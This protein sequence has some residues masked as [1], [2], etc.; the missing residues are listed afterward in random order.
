MIEERQ[1]CKDGEENADAEH[2]VQPSG[3]LRLTG[4]RE[5]Q[6]FFTSKAERQGELGRGRFG[7]RGDG[8]AEAGQFRGMQ[9]A[10]DMEEG[11]QRT[12]PSLRT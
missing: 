5:G 6:W 8:V 1:P 12:C 3:P 11:A 2:R 4:R 7:P 10:E 9:V